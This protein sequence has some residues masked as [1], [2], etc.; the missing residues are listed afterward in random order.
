MQK[1]REGQQRKAHSEVRARTCSTSEEKQYSFAFNETCEQSSARP[2]GARHDGKILFKSCS[3]CGSATH[4]ATQV[5]RLSLHYFVRHIL[6]IYHIRDFRHIGDC[7]GVS[8]ALFS[9]VYLLGRGSGSASLATCVLKQLML[10]FY[11]VVLYLL[12]ELRSQS[13]I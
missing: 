12:F 11:L 10:L 8:P 9:V 2:V 3:L 5:Y 1:L 13:T 4:R 7:L 6:F